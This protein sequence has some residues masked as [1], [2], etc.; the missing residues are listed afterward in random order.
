MLVSTLCICL[1]VRKPTQKLLTDFD[2]I[3]Y[4]FGGP[5][6]TSSLAVKF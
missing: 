5:E 4:V 2:K 6:R 3:L 1:S